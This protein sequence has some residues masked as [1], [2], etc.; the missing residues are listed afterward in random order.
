MI[1]KLAL[2]TETANINLY[3]NG[4]GYLSKGGN[5]TRAS[6]RIVK[7]LD[8]QLPQVC[9]QIYTE[10]AVVVYKDNR[11][12]F[13]TEKGMRIWLRR[14]LP[15]QLEVIERLRLLVVEER[16]VDSIRQELQ[17]K[18]PE[19][20]I[21]GPGRMES[22]YCVGQEGERQRLGRWLHQYR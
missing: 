4:L 14:R 17:G 12:T 22:N 6:R 15:A 5:A 9:R 10:T 7:R 16:K 1:F 11:F 18:V 8:M 2:T 3:Y 20:S 21:S 13:A 19:A